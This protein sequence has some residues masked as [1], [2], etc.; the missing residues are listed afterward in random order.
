M[1]KESQGRRFFF[2]ENAVQLINKIRY[3]NYTNPNKDVMMILQ[4]CEKRWRDDL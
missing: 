4:W 2:Y 3:I 1:G